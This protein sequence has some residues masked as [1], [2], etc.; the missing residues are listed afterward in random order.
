MIE[1]VLHSDIGG[2]ST[3]KREMEH[4][5]DYL[6]VCATLLSPPCSEELAAFEHLLAARKFEAAD[7]GLPAYCAGSL[8]GGGVVLVD[9]PERAVIGRVD[10]HRGIVAPTG[11]SGRLHASAVDDD[12]LAQG[13]LA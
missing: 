6:F 13:H 4:A 2:S 8:A 12:A 10:I 11:I 3:L 5:F 9:V 1:E 7:P